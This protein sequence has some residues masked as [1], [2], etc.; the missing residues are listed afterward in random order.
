MKKEIEVI[1]GEGEGID[2][3]ELRGKVVMK[4]LNFSEKNML[5]E[6]SSDVKVLGN[7]PQV[8][9]STAKL[10]EMAL[11][12]SIIEADIKKITYFQDK[13]TKEIKATEVG[14]A[15]DITGIQNLPIDIGESLFQEYLALNTLSEKKNVT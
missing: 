11:V 14:Y 10:K 7:I 12:R 3:F 2:R 1:Y 6:D 4:R 9:V 15:M 5:E 13:Q 8:K